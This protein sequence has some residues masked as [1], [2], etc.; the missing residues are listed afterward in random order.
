M[1]GALMFKRL[2]VRNMQTLFEA[3]TSWPALC[4]IGN[5]YIS[6]A[7]YGIVRIY[8]DIN[9]DHIVIVNNFMTDEMYHFSELWVNKSQADFY[10]HIYDFLLGKGWG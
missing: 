10:L 4:K 3:L 9:G 1:N 7:F 8:D 6:N 2:Q 5:N